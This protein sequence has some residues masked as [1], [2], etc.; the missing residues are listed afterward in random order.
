[1]TRMP[2][3]TT[4]AGTA[5]TRH[6]KLFETVEDV[7]EASGTV[8]GPVGTLREVKTGFVDVVLP[9][10]KRVVGVVVG[11]VAISATITRLLVVEQ[12]CWDGDLLTEQLAL[13]A[14]GLWGVY[15][16]MVGWFVIVNQLM[17]RNEKLV[18]WRPVTS[19]S[20]RWIA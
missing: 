13:Q 1:M 5:S 20:I 8:T 6:E 16:Y 4:A 19:L 11:F 2:A 17:C 3:P 10:G 15:I 18:S 12:V 9:G 14:K 7:G